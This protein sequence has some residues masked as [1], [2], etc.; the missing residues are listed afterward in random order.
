MIIATLLASL[1]LLSNGS[2]ATKDIPITLSSESTSY[3]GNTITFDKNVSV[4]HH[5]GKIKAGSATITGNTNE[6]KS[7]FHTLQLRDN[8]SIDIKEGTNF[9]CQY[10][11]L[12]SLTLTGLFSGT[13]NNSPVIYRD[14]YTNSEGTAIPIM[15][16]SLIMNVKL[17]KPSTN[18]D[19]EQNSY[20][21]NNLFAQNSVILNYGNDFTAFADKAIYH[22]IP[23]R[24]AKNSEDTFSGMI[25]LLPLSKSSLCRVIT[26]D[27]DFINAKEMRFDTEKKTISCMQA[28]GQLRLNASL[29]NMQFSA[30]TISWDTQQK[31]ITLNKPIIIKQKQWGILTNE[32]KVLFNGAHADNKRFDSIICLGETTWSHVDIIHGNTH[33][34]TCHG[35]MSIDQNSG[36]ISFESPLENGSTPIDKQIIYNTTTSTVRADTMTIFCDM[37]EKI[38]TPQSIAIEGNVKIFNKGSLRPGDTT[39][40]LQY[41]IADSVEYSSDMKH[42]TLR[43]QE[44]KRV[45][46]LDRI[47]NMQMSANAIEITKNSNEMESIR[48][49]GTTRFTFNEEEFIQLKE[50]FNLS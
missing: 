21:V 19:K 11:E 41:A 42:L 17:F 48:G 18:T 23:R 7:Q 30:G 38:M 14:L 29:N 34:V 40:V 8:V 5:I 16:R 44:N 10:A 22:Y 32:D 35:I 13:K 31:R 39:P 6:K 46:F 4:T 27:R 2:H 33:D 9:H 26:R 25:F 15:L 47:N 45:L 20:V 36:T 49:I 1:S 24:D 28:T 12:N 37:N 3:D 50:Q 43:A